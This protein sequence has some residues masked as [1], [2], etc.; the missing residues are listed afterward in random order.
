M[1]DPNVTE[2]VNEL[3]KHIDAVN[4]LNEKLYDQGVSYVLK[5]SFDRETNVKVLEVQYLK[6]TVEYQ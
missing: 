2:L 5:D 3:N 4:K 1:R 6:Q